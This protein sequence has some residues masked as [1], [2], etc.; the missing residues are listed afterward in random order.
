[1]EIRS[2]FTDR[3]WISISPIYR[4]ILNHQFLGGL[5]SGKLSV[6]RFKEYVIQD[7]LYLHDFSTSLQILS[8]KAPKQKWKS[9]F[10]TDSLVALEVEKSLH[11][12]FFKQWRFRKNILRGRQNPANTAYASYILS[13]TSTR[14]FH[15]GLA[16]VLPCYWIYL[17]VGRHLEK[18][19]S[20]N[21]LYQRWIDTYASEEFEAS[22]NSALDIMNSLRLNATEKHNCEQRFRTAAIYEFMFWDASYRFEKW[23]Y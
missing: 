5:T 10:A 2:Q 6:D 17:K 7:S 13:S 4:G 18:R 14:P 22:V 21:S 15:E 1:M 3:L 8:A 19:G 16:S 23:K 11:E 20:P 9:K 12:S